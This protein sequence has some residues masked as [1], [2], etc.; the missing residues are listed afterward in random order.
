MEGLEWRRELA[1]TEEKCG[2]F[3]V[4]VWLREK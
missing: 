2:V 1:R 4:Y 3:I